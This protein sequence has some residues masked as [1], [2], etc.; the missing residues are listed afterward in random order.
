MFS[1]SREILNAVFDLLD[2]ELEYYVVM[3]KYDEMPDIIPSDIDMCITDNDFCK[4]DCLVKCL[5]DNLKMAVVQKIWHNYK[6]CAYI[7]VPL[8]TENK[9]RLQLDFFSDFSVE[10]TPCLITYKEIHSNVRKYGR[11]NVPNYNVEFVF[12]MMRRIYKNDLTDANCDILRALLENSISSI[13]SYA[14][15]YICENDLCMIIDALLDHNYCLLREMQPYLWKKLRRLSF[16]NSIGFYY[17]KYWFVQMVRYTYRAWYPVGCTVALL[18]PDGC[19]KSTVI[20][21][22]KD[23][24]WGAFHGIE[25]FH[26]RPRLLKNIGHYNL[27]RR[28]RE[29]D[30]NSAPHLVVEDSLGKSWVRYLFYNIDFILGYWLKIYPK[31]IKKKLIIFDRYYY[32]YLVDIKRYAYSF[33]RW[34]PRLF[35]FMIPAPDLIV[36]LHADAGVVYSRKNELGIDEIMRQMSEYLSMHSLNLNVVHVSAN[37]SIE[38]VVAVV[39]KEIIAFKAR[40]TSKLIC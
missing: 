6:K 4:L 22:L 18:A 3:N 36:V 20:N 32:D 39:T 14:L 10:S 1:S 28:T 5:A 37:G 40:Q 26:F 29:A 27:L 9:F 11:F 19:G 35:L 15:K 23:T 24:C 31:V 13:R 33:P 7:I 17:I 21:H 12:L 25:V 2:K 38:S 30:S 34:V 8:Y 16:R